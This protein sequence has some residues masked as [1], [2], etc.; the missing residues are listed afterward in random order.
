[1]EK[2]K[3]PFSVGMIQNDFEKA[4][5]SWGIRSLPWLIVTDRTHIIRSTGFRINELN[6]KI[7]EM[8]DEKR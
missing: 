4:R 5:F 8:T 2:Y 3:V 6:E 1:V 7:K